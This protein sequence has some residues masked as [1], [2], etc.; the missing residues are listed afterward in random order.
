MSLRGADCAWL[1]I[2]AT[3][4]RAVKDANNKGEHRNNHSGDAE[5][6]RIAHQAEKREPIRPPPAAPAYRHQSQQHH[7]DNSERQSE[8]HR[9]LVWV[10]LAGCGILQCASRILLPTHAADF[11]ADLESLAPGS[12]VLG[13]SDVIAAEVE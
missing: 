3:R 6:R 2:R 13:S 12:S 7:C 11:G 4:C 10:G 1:L 8:G 9:Q 5:I